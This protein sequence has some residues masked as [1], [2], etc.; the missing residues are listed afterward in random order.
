MALIAVL[1]CGCLGPVEP[2]TSPPQPNKTAREVVAT[3]IED[4]YSR[5]AD[6]PQADYRLMK[7]LGCE[8]KVID[9]RDP[10]AERFKVQADREGLPALIVY[11]AKT[12]EVLVSQKVTSKDA[13]KKSVE[14]AKSSKQ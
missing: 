10:Y 13:L 6:S 12:G 2:N 3:I 5:T 14:G 9:K 11:D 1:C 4:S 7:G 8:F